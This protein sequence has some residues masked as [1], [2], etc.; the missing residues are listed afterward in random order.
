[1]PLYSRT[2]DRSSTPPSFLSNADT[3]GGN[4]GSPV[5]DGTGKM[6]GLNFDRVFE[7]IAGDY[8]YNP[9]RSRN[10]MVST[11]AILWYLQ[12]VVQAYPLVSEIRST[13]P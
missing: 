9:D 2:H 4:S 1:L 6:V 10:V 8:G 11:R 5:L 3:T 12:H 7:N 13:H